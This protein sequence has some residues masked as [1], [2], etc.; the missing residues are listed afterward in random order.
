MGEVPLSESLGHNVVLA[1]RWSKVRFRTSLLPFSRFIL[2]SGT[3]RKKR[4]RMVLC[5]GSTFEEGPYR[6]SLVANIRLGS[7][8]DRRASNR[9]DKTKG[10]PKN[11]YAETEYENPS[12]KKTNA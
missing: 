6:Q 10:T 2:G 7:R 9:K 5:E 3:T 4:T 12:T 11:E 8:D 1:F